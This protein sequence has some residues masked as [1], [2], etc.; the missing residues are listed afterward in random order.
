MIRILVAEGVGSRELYGRM[1]AINSEISPSRLTLVWWFK[2][3]FDKCEL[4]EEDA[5]PGQVQSVITLE[6][7]A[8]V[9]NSVLGNRKI[10]LSEIHQSHTLLHEHMNFWKICA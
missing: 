1:K 4:Q 3:F 8:E 7:V 10:I 2:W 5:C 9:N 6:M